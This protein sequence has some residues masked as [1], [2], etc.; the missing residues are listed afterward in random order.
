MTNIRYA[1]VSPGSEVVDNVFA[2]RAGVEV[3]LG[4]ETTSF[5]R[6]YISKFCFVSDH[7]NEYKYN[8]IQ[9]QEQIKYKCKYKYKYNMSNL[10]MSQWRRGSLK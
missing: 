10:C 9:L 5:P 4:A 6:G 3:V 8:R 7:L 1:Y 2:A